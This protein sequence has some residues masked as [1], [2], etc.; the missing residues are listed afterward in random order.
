MCWTFV[1]NLGCVFGIVCPWGGWGLPSWF[2]GRWVHLIQG[3]AQ[4]I[5]RECRALFRCVFCRWGRVQ[6]EVWIPTPFP[7]CDSHFH[8]S[9]CWTPCL[10]SFGFPAWFA[11]QDEP[12]QR[13][14]S[15]RRLCVGGGWGRGKSHVWSLCCTLFLLVRSVGGS[16]ERGLNPIP[17]TPILRFALSRF[18]NYWHR[19]GFWIPS[20]VRISGDPFQR[21]DSQDRLRAGIGWG[22]GKSHHVWFLCCDRLGFPFRFAFSWSSNCWHHVCWYFW[23]PSVV[24]FQG[25]LFQWSF[26]PTVCVGGGWG[27]EPH[28]VWFHVASLP[29]P[30]CDSRV[31]FRQLLKTVLVV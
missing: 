26:P 31:M 21:L 29:F 9:K 5:T 19:V 2:Y 1:R 14:G 10:F 3:Q 17:I 20:M 27:G 7:C 16:L 8:D 4:Q 13:L 28:H 18:G 30:D 6:R 23:F 22:G 25:W 12:F 15:Q 11:F 24:R